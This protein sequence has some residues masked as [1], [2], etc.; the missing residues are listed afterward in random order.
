M[1]KTI[2]QKEYRAFKAWKKEQQQD[3]K[4]ADFKAFMA[5]AGATLLKEQPHPYTRK[6]DGKQVHGTLFSYKLK[7]GKTA[8]YQ[9]TTTRTQP[10]K[11]F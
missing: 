1:K 7:S 9:N 8:Q 11:V 10:F 4:V 5:S 2:S 3:D 6:T